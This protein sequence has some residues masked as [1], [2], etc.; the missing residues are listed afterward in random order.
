MVNIKSTYTY[1]TQ[2]ETRSR[3]DCSNINSWAI[4]DS[5]VIIACIVQFSHLPRPFNQPINQP[6][7]T[8]RPSPITCLPACL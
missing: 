6:K 1:S 3:Y 2:F 4:V 8:P 7:Q 5:K